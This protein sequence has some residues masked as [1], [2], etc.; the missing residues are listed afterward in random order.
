MEEW[1]NGRLEKSEKQPS[2]LPPFVMSYLSEVH[3]QLLHFASLTCHA[4]PDDAPSTCPVPTLPSSSAIRR[5]VWG[6]I[7]GVL[8]ANRAG[9]QPARG[10]PSGLERMPTARC[11]TAPCTSS[12]GRDD[13]TGRDRRGCLSRRLERS[14]RRC[15]VRGP[16][17]GGRGVRTAGVA[18]CF[19][20]F[21]REDWQAPMP[22]AAA[23]TVR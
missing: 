17:P 4:N 10:A 1:N 8:S 7:R 3:T 14:R 21:L 9:G 13:T 19:L 23:P 16:A 5:G 2:I 11:R 18:A 12:P 6:G 15:P 20:R 22:C